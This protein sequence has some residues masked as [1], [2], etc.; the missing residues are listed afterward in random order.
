MCSDLE[1]LGIGGLSFFV[2]ISRAQCG[3]N[4]GLRAEPGL[5]PYLDTDVSKYREI[6]SIAF[7]ICM[8]AHSSNSDPKSS[9]H[10]TSD[11][12]G[13]FQGP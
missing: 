10:Q 6:P 1:P 13:T 5:Q 2:I 4:L 3:R 11:H 9:G 12:A 7:L 8:V